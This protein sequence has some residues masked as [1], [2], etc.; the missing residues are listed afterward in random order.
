MDF[1]ETA[2][3]SYVAAVP[4]ACKNTFLTR[5]RR[6][7]KRRKMPRGVAGLDTVGVHEK[8]NIWETGD[9]Q[10]HSF[11]DLQTF[12]YDFTISFSLIGTRKKTNRVTL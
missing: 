8:G 10:K 6:R 9:T 12:V 1:D 2:R 3:S 5:E 4:Q 11:N 7:R